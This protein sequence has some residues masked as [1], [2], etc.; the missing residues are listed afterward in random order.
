M[1]DISKKL[2]IN[3][4]KVSPSRRILLAEKRSVFSWVINMKINPNVRLKLITNNIFPKSKGLF[5]T[6]ESSL[7]L[8]VNK[9]LG[10]KNRSKDLGWKL[11]RKA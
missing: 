9:S 7:L 2:S 6:K 5:T 3:V 4:P 11:Y 10:L 8:I 1:I